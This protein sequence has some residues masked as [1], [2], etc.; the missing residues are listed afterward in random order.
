[1]TFVPKNPAILPRARA[2][3]KNM[4]PQ[5]RHLWY[6]FLRDYPVKIYKQRPIESFIADFYCSS[7]LLV[8]E[9]DG[10]QHF[11]EQGL[12]YDRERSAIFQSYGIQ[13]IRFTNHEVDTQFNSVCSQIMRTIKERILLI[14]KNPAKSRSPSAKC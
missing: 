4:T 9:I 5:E 8:I 3:R 10:S 13:V 11:T 14:S 12:A 2:L 7:A 6:D 1:M